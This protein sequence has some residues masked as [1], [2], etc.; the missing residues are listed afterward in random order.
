MNKLQN[1]IEITDTGK[2]KTSEIV[3]Q[4]RKKFKVY[5]YDEKNLDKNFPAPKKATTRYFKNTQEAD[6]ENKN[7]SYNDLEKEGKI[8][9]CISLRER[10]LMELIYFK[11]NDKHLD[12]K[13][14][15]LCAGSRYPVGHVPRVYWSPGYGEV[16][17]GWCSPSGACSF[18]RARFAVSK[19]SSSKLEPLEHDCQYKAK[20]DEIK[21]II[22]LPITNS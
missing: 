5:V 16:S 15:T 8:K 21:K 10:L 20:L 18:L 9:D 19:S 13:N 17:V 1:T 14:W 7:K 4:M 12:E 11:E 3:A 2:L 22:K 6:E